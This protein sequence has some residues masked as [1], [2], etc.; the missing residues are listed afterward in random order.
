MGFFS[1]K[2]KVDN[3][4]LFK[5]KYKTI[6]QLSMQAHQEGDFQ[7]KESLLALIVK[8]YETL[9]EYIDQGADFDKE[10]FM[11]L[12]KNAEKELQSIHEINQDI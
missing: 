12:K 8:E 2:Q 3:N 1:K 7:I 10:H 11:A 6:N 9:L 4:A 5:D